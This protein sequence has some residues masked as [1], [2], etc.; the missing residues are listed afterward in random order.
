VTGVQTC[1][2]PILFT[3]SLVVSLS[4]SFLLHQSWSLSK[5]LD[6]LF[7]VGL[8]L[9]VIYA[10]MVLM[11]V[12]FFTAFFKSFKHF[13]SRINKKEQHIRDSEKR[14]TDI[15][16]YQKSFPNKKSFVEIGL[17]FCTVGL[18][19]STAFYYFGR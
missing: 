11:E 15:V 2:L 3:I 17:L 12:E 18:L 4:L 5:W 7:L 14:S 9:L 13:Y 10:I 19:V 8:L 6:S 1:A 16:S